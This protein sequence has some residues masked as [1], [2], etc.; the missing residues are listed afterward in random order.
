MFT[1]FKMSSKKGFIV[2]VASIFLMSGCALPKE[3][4]SNNLEVEEG[5]FED[6]VLSIETEKSEIPLPGVDGITLFG[7]MNADGDMFNEITVQTK[8]S[9]KSFTWENVTNPSYYPIV[10]MGDVDD[11][12]KEEIIIIL[13][14]GYGTELNIQE[15]HILKMDDLS[16]KEIENPLK[17]IK[18]N[19]KSVISKNDGKVH[20]SI[21]SF[22]TKMEKTY[23]ELDAS[24]WNEEVGFGS[25]VTYEL[26]GNRI[27]AT[28]PGSVSTIEFPLTALVEYGPDLKMKNIELV[29][30]GYEEDTRMAYLANVW[31]NALKTRDGKPRYEMMSNEAKEKFVKEQIN[32]G[33]EN[34]N[35][36]IGVSSPWVVDFEVK[37]DD[38]TAAITYVT[39]T[40]EPAFYNM[41][42]VLTFARDN[43]GKLVVDDYQTILE[44]QL[45][46][47]ADL[48]NIHENAN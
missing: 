24:I 25:I 35:Y 27:M 30:V 44:D 37:V 12:G 17:A 21:E 31:A 18:E 16:E 7:K 45:V 11:D 43:N 36:N 14:L 47:N 38:M 2:S 34:W 23:N 41:K 9:S 28:V 1:L 8:E 6:K 26:L 46:E 32:R 5:T 19:V 15:I 39:K 48:D 40:S 4:T 22:E 13:T 3:K 20:V 29:D 10:R 42:E 33:G